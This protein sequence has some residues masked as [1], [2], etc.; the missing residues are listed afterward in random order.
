VVCLLSVQ[1]SG[2]KLVSKRRVAVS[3]AGLERVLL[4]QNPVI[5][6]SFVGSIMC[7]KKK[8]FQRC[9]APPAFQ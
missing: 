5:I 7:L 6:I 1:Y 2:S 9:M 3:R 8:V 4:L